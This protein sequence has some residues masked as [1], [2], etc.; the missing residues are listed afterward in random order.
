MIQFEPVAEKTDGLIQK[1]WAWNEKLKK[2]SMK[3]LSSVFDFDLNRL[4]I[5]ENRQILTEI[6]KMF[7]LFYAPRL[8]HETRNLSLTRRLPN[9]Q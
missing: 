8:Q 6:C 7:H 2:F 5:K 3:F 9:V 1:L 4:S